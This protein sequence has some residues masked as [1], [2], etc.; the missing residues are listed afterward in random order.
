MV[1]LGRVTLIWVRLPSVSAVPVV[2]VGVFERISE[3]PQEYFLYCHQEGPLVLLNPWAIH[4]CL[5]SSQ[6]TVSIRRVGWQAVRSTLSIGPYQSGNLFTRES[7]VAVATQ[8]DCRTYADFAQQHGS[9]F[10][11]GYAN[12]ATAVKRTLARNRAAKK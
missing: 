6:K 7:S 10:P 9:D 4:G 1:P 8:S 12:T 5:S 3:L 11:K 2:C